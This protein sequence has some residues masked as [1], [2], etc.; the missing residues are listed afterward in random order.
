[1]GF[2]IKEIKY[3]E[4]YLLFLTDPTNSGPRFS[5]KLKGK[6]IGTIPIVLKNIEPTPIY[7][8]VNSRKGSSIHRITLDFDIKEYLKVLIRDKKI[9]P[10]TFK[11]EHHLV[12]LYI[13]IFL[14][15]R[16]PYLIS[17]F[18]LKNMSDFNLIDFSMY[19]IFDFDVNGLEGY[20][21]DYSGYDIENDII[22][23]YDM[24]KLYGGFSTISKPTHFE[25][26]LTRNL[27]IDNE[28]LTLGNNLFDSQGELTSALQIAFITLPPN[29]SFQTAFVLSGGINKEEMI[30]NITEGKKR[31]M[32]YLPQINRSITSKQRNQ[33]DPAFID[34]NL[35]EGKDCK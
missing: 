1:M 5:F 11:K 7:K 16:E 29:K 33:Q 28:R 31:A 6:K 21:N 22:Y 30:K 3:K 8:L 34:L 9:K 10:I 25:S 4:K 17:F 13:D 2:S 12:R 19:F 23:Q 15:P 35:K 20:D 14:Y 26:C 32:K 27:K 24:T 18:T